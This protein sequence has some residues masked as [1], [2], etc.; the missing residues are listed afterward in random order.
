M[1]MVANTEQ[2]EQRE[3]RIEPG[4]VKRKDTPPRPKTE[5]KEGH[6]WEDGEELDS[7]TDRLGGR[8]GNKTTE[9]NVTASA[10]QERV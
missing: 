8:Q 3:T 5:P 9:N 7:G 10:A 1:I 2:M 6:T 4:P